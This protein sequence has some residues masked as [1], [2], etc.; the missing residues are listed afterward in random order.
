ML[1]LLVP[2]AVLKALVNKAAAL[3]ASKINSCLKHKNKR[4]CKL[5]CVKVVKFFCCMKLH[6]VSI[7][8][9]LISF[10]YVLV[11]EYLSQQTLYFLNLECAGFPAF[12]PVFVW[13]FRVCRVQTSL[14]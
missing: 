4:N 10:P 5:S 3:E 9:R 11:R 1:S 8:S 13:V 12:G 7:L 14:G 6:N 2:R